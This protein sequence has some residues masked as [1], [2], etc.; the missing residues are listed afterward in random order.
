MK[1]KTKEKIKICFLADKHGLYDDRIYWKMSLSLLKKGFEIYYILISDKD[2]EGI[3]K[4]GVNYSSFK[5]KKFSSNR[6]I[7]YIIKYSR[8]KTNYD[9]LFEKAKEIEAD[10]YHFHDLNINRIGKKLKLLPHKPIVIYD[11]RDP[12][13][14]NIKDYIG[15]ESILKPLINLYANYINNWEKKCAKNYDFVISNEENIRDEFRKVLPD[16]NVDVIYNYTNLYKKRKEMIK[17]YDLIY[18]GGITKFRG[19][20][21]II[22]TIKILKEDFPEIKMLFLGNFFTNEF[23][24]EMNK[25]IVRHKLISNIILKES[26]PYNEVANYYNKSRIGLGIFLPI[27]THKIILQIKI[28]EYMAMGL[29]IIGSNF[30][31]INNYILDNNVGIT[32]NPLNSQEIANAIKKILITPSLYSKFKDNGIKAVKEKYNWKLMEEKLLSIYERLLFKR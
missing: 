15:S 4:E 16:N 31:H 25:H 13:A 29:P 32:V 11:A 7:N 27:K 20:F 22:E 9:K 5:I 6:Y 8:S 30:G 21:K 23:K 24:T 19:A 17:E 26:V 2:S 18:C 10:I 1:E 12:F 14:Q 28:F 3:T